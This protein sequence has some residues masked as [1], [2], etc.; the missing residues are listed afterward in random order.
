MLDR[1]GLRPAKYVVTSDGLV[2]LASEFGVLDIDPARVVAKGRVQPGKMFLVD[3]DAG[4]SHLRRRDQAPGGD[5][6]AVSR[7]ARREPDDAVDAARGRQ[8]PYTS[9]ARRACPPAAGVRLHRGGSEDDPGADGRRRG[10]EPVGSM[11]VDTP[12]A[13]LSERPQLLFRY[14]KQ[15]FAQVTNPPIDPI[16]EETVMSL[17]SCVGGEGNLLEET[18]NSAACSSCRTRSSRND[19]LA[20]CAQR[21]RRFSRLH[22][23]HAL[24]GRRRRSASAT[25]TTRSTSCAAQR[26]ARSTTGPASSS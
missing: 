10:E 22:V 13:V 24:S 23:A 9:A 17:V 6:E 3:T 12:L 25:S 26:A 16:R 21:P 14:F 5:A 2:V 7:V 20:R 11:G 8:S 1:N 19:D 18:P 15:Q 4:R